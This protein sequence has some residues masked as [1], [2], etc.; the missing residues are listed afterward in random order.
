MVGLLGEGDNPVIDFHRWDFCS[1]SLVRFAV[2]TPQLRPGRSSMPGLSMSKL[3]LTCCFISQSGGLTDSLSLSL[4]QRPR[5]SSSGRTP[6]GVLCVRRITG[7]K[8]SGGLRYVSLWFDQDRTFMDL[9]VYR[10]RSYNFTIGKQASSRPTEINSWLCPFGVSVH[11]YSRHRGCSQGC[12]GS[13]RMYIC[14]SRTCLKTVRLCP[15]ITYE[16]HRP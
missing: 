9:L 15:L 2:F 6:R 7:E 13:T 8:R 5:R 14:V 16:N 3:L 11:S 4:S 12:N 1:S 10:V